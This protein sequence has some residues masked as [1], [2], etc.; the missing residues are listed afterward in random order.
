[1]N[2]SRL[3][4]V[5]RA[6]V[7]RGPLR[8]AI[9]LC[10]LLGVVGLGFLFES[11]LHVSAVAAAFR[12][13]VGQL[14]GSAHRRTPGQPNADN[15]HRQ[16]VAAGKS[17]PLSLNEIELRKLLRAAPLEFTEAAR[18]V[19]IVVTLPLPDGRLPGFVL[20]NRR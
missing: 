2:S 7:Y 19:Q 16:Q 18:E 3:T 11:S 17:R 5:V 4:Q 12:G 9:A 10:L 15:P 8:L 14:E 13:R 1:M 6:G 20:R